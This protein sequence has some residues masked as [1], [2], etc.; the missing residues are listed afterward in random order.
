MTARVHI[1]P[2]RSLRPIGPGPPLV[3]LTLSGAR[4]FS[5]PIRVGAP[6]LV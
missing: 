5:P 1:A 2:V 4:P 3:Y 6:Y